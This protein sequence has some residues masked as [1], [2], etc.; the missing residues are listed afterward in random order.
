MDPTKFLTVAKS[1]RRKSRE[2]ARVGPQ[3]HEAFIRSA[4]DRAYYSAMLKTKETVT[5]CFK[6]CDKSSFYCI[7]EM[8][9]IIHPTIIGIL[10]VIDPSLASTMVNLRRKR[11]EASYE[12]DTD[13]DDEDL[14]ISVEDAVFVIDCQQDMSLNI[15]QRYSRKEMKPNWV[16]RI[17][18]EIK[19]RMSR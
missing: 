8:K 3:V 2:L 17:A 13:I 14:K 11:N 7:Q 15:A 16:G 18:G 5:E 9:A 12:M 1:I 4:I 19:G 6:Q 10:E